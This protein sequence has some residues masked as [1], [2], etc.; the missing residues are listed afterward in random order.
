[1]A[2]Q[3][4]TTYYN[5]TGPKDK[6]EPKHHAERREL[7]RKLRSEQ[8]PALAKVKRVVKPMAEK[9][10]G[11]LQDRA[12][13]IAQEMREPP[14]RGGGRGAR[15]QNYGGTLPG[16]HQDP[17]GVG[18][19]GGMNANPWN[20]PAHPEPRAAPRKKRR[21]RRAAPQPRQSG[22]MQMMGIPKHMRWMF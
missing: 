2:E 13:G 3:K 22:G 4:V 19:F 15:K 6:T 20:N 9:V 12:A 14:R 18:G 1:M 21:K 7:N 17:F 5:K 11:F 10:G 16:I 8:E